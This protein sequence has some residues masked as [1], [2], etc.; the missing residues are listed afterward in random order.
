[1]KK[2]ISIIII[3]FLP[4]A[5]LAQA[6]TDILVFSVQGDVMIKRG[7]NII[8]CKRADKILTGDIVQLKKGELSLVSRNLKRVTLE[9]KGTY[10]YQ[11]I[12]QQFNRANAS[13]ENRFLV[14]VIDKMTHKSGEVAYAGGV[15]RGTRGAMQPM[16]SAIILADV[17]RFS[18]SNPNNQQLHFFI[19]NEEHQVLYTA[20]TTD[21]VFVM[22]KGKAAW[23]KPGTYFWEAVTLDKQGIAEQSFFIPA[24]EERNRLLTNYNQLQKSF[25]KFPAGIRK[26]LMNEVLMENR[27]VKY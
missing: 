3:L 20:Q 21:S 1:M 7:K 26:Q 5:M 25:S 18:F 19:L 16:D 11:Q 10:S 2:F 22:Q 27:W 9:K 24:T 17:I 12:V 8:P 23:W 6:G 13:L 4:L 14:Q 15:V